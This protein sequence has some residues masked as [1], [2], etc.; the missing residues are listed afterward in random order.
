[1][2]PPGRTS[3]SRHEGDTRGG[4]VII[5]SAICSNFVSMGDAEV[6]HQRHR[7]RRVREVTRELD[8]PTSLTPAPNHLLRFYFVGCAKEVNLINRPVVNLFGSRVRGTG[9][10]M[11]TERFD[12]KLFATTN[13]ERKVHQCRYC[14][15]N[16]RDKE[17]CQRQE[18]QV[19]S[20]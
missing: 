9:T 3:N 6:Q 12:D 2:Y 14:C 11:I 18:D 16:T 8:V 17:G 20:L 13:R 7:T 4:V 5:I 10:N 1:M 19:S 15:T